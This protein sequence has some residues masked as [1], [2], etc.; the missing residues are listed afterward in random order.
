MGS[1][2]IRLRHDIAK[3]S[4]KCSACILTLFLLLD[5]TPC[6]CIRRFDV[7]LCLI[8]YMGSYCGSSD[9]GG[10]RF[11]CVDATSFDA[12]LRWFFES[13]SRSYRDWSGLL[14]DDP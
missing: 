9:A 13:A 5:D 12:V 10:S 14:A 2:S 8:E 11:P 3:C 7:I 1:V 4:G 6:G